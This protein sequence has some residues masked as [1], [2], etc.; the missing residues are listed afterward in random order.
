MGSGRLGKDRDSPNGSSGLGR[1]GKDRDGPRWFLDPR[2]W[3]WLIAACGYNGQHCTLLPTLPPTRRIILCSALPCV[4]PPG[5]GCNS[6]GRRRILPPP[7]SNT[8]DDLVGRP[9]LACPLR[10]RLQQRWT[11]FQLF[12]L[13]RRMTLFPPLIVRRGDG[14]KNNGRRFNYAPS[15]LPPTQ[16]FA[17]AAATAMENVAS[18]SHPLPPRG[19]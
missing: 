16:S 15:P 3:W 2:S 12:P 19:G 8:A 17:V 10:R 4:N 7:S 1:L 9:S 5:G 6:A 18:F 14:C 13:T 11:T